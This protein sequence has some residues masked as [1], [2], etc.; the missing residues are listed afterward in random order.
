MHACTS[1]ERSAAPIEPSQTTSASSVAA[2]SESVEVSADSTETSSTSPTPGAF[3]PFANYPWV[4]LTGPGL[5]TGKTRLSEGEQFLVWAQAPGRQRRLLT[6]ERLPDTQW[7]EFRIT[8]STPH[9][10]EP[11]GGKKDWFIPSINEAIHL[12]DA[13]FGKSADL[14]PG[15]D[16]D[17]QYYYWSS[18]ND[19]RNNNRVI[20]Q[21]FQTGAG[22]TESALGPGGETRKDGEIHL[23]PIRAF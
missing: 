4:E 11:G 17:V 2:P 13:S 23:R 8:I 5:D 6:I 1:V 20:A 12:F 9:V 15:F 16:R 22:D 10:C 14:F 18:S 21:D 19:K 3:N 7:K